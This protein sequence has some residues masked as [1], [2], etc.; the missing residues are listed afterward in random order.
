MWVRTSGDK[1]NLVNLENGNHFCVLARR[2]P[3]TP[4]GGNEEWA[5]MFRLGTLGEAEWETA[6]FPT[7]ALAQAAMDKL[8]KWIATN[9]AMYGEPY[10][11]TQVFSFRTLSEDDEF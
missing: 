4:E 3:S 7:K 2:G 11:P 5:V 9:G 6:H 8:E 1:S 10:A